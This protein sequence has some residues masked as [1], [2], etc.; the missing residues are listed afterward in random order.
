MSN[1]VCPKQPG[2]QVRASD[3]PLGIKDNLEQLGHAMQQQRAGRL[4]QSR[5]LQPLKASPG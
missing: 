4:S 3:T 5:R 2:D 1:A